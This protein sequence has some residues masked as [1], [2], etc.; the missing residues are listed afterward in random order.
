MSKTGWIIL[1]A[2]GLGIPIAIAV[3]VPKTTMS[4]EATA[5]MTNEEKITVKRDPETGLIQDVVVHRQ[6]NER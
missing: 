4:L 1:G 5:S 3:L 2:L 6:V